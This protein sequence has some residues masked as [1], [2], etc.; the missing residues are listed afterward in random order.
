MAK[1]EFI[2]DGNLTF[3]QAVLDLLTKFKLT[4]D[5]ELVQGITIECNTEKST[6]YLDKIRSH[7]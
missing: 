1:T 2:G 5:N 4:I 6:V 3:S 7:K